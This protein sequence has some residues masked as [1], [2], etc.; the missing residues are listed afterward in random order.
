MTANNMPSSATCVSS[1]GQCSGGS[2]LACDGPEDCGGG[3]GSGQFCCATINFTSMPDAGV[4]FNGGNA[5]CSTSCAFAFGQGSVTSRLC[6]EDVDCT[7]LTGPLNTALN[8]CCSSTM[9]PGMH[10]C[11]AAISQLGVT[12]P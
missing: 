1:A 4:S 2:L 12:C 3:T 11:A 7:G 10:F 9:A 5:S 8:K 6:H